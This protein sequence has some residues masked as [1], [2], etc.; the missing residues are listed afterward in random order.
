MSSG[1]DSLN[2]EDAAACAL[3]KNSHL[4]FFSTDPAA[5]SAAKTL[6]ITE[7]TVR[8][9]CVKFA[10]ETGKIWGVWG[11]KDENELRRTLSVNADG[12]EVRRG[13]FPQCPNCNARTSKLAVSVIDLEGGGR[14]TTAKVVTCSVCDFTWRSRSSANAVVAYHTDRAVKLARALKVE[15]EEANKELVKAIYEAN[16]TQAV[17][18]AAQIYHQTA[19]DEDKHSETT[20]EAWEMLKLA[21]KENRLAGAAVTRLTNLTTRLESEYDEAYTRSKS[22]PTSAPEG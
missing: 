9:D 19:R 3:P 14:W 20:A 13:R 11:G 4:D 1:E 22:S 21:K 15:L 7:C 12:V 10:L 16:I 8:T 2:W 5:K 6:C 18:H 17:Q